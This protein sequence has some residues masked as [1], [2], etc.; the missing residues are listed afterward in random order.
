MSDA[1]NAGALRFPYIL[2]DLGSTLI[3]FEGDW[4]TVLREAAQVAG[5]S[6]IALG[7]PLREQ[8]FSSAYYALMMEYYQKR[9]G[10]F[11]EY[12]AWFVLN[13]AVKSQGCTAA[14]EHLHQALGQFYAIT[15]AHWRT[16]ADA[17][18][19]L[20]ALL[21]LGY[22]LDIVSN[23]S[24]DADVQILVERAGLRGCFDFVLTSE[25]AG[26]RKPSPVIFDQALAY[27][28][29]QPGQAV[30][31]GDTLIADVVGAKQSGIA[32]VWISRRVDTPE[33]RAAANIVLP[34]RTICSLSELPHL[35]E[36]WPAV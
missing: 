8:D 23:A 4:D 27:W 17:V 20:A 11:V 19:T 34:D 10:Q 26:Y 33:N 1:S 6:L 24:D 22:R 25:R 21:G 16:E 14:D 12:P 29:A 5:A 28:G 36:T 2:F 13:E 30:M 15:Q 31:V 18:P 3:Y 7:Y 9:S 35:L 32:S